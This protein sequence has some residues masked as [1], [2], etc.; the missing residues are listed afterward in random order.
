[1]NYLQWR[2]EFSIGI[3]S[4]DFEHQ[5]LM[6]MINIIYAELDNRRDVEEIKQTM[7]EVHAEISA[8]FAL[9]ERIMRHARYVEFEE[10]KNDHENLL[11]QI[12]TM[13]DA[14]END[15]EH[16]LDDLSEALADWFRGH[17]VTFDARLHKGLGDH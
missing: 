12:R 3:D 16:A 8:H 6:N 13:M 7:G 11:D 5:E 4:V 10:H 9:E 15:P 14:I 17:F 2:E 1:M